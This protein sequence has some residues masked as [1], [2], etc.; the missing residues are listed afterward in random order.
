MKK[1]LIIELV[2][3]AVITIA[4]IILMFTYK[5]ERIEFTIPS[6]FTVQE[7]SQDAF[8]PIQ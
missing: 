1:M 8:I 3:Y 4:G 7:E 5:E 6:D 2:I